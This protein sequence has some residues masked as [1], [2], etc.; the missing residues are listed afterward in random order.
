MTPPSLAM[1]GGAAGA[2][3]PFVVFL[4][5]VGWLALAGAPDERGFWP[6]LLAA[7]AV[8]LLLAKDRHQYSETL[9]AGMSQP[10]VLLMVMAWLLAGVLGTLMGAAGFV[11][12]LVW[13]TGQ[14]G[15]SGGAYVAAAFVACAAV[16]TST[17]TSFGTILICGPL[18]YPAGA[19]AGADPRVLAGA[20]LAGATF[21]DS[22][23]PISDTTIASSG[24]Q[25]ADI[26]GTVRARLK[27]VLPAGVVAAMA[28]LVLGAFAGDTSA[29]ASPVG[30]R[31]GG[32]PMALVPVLIVGLLLARRHLV[33][34]LMAGIA[35]AITIA[36]SFG[37]LSPAQLLRVES[38]SYA[39]KSLITDGLERGVGVTV[40][41]LL[42]VGL[43][44]GLEASGTLARLV[45]RSRT[46]GR[47]SARWTSE[48][49]IVAT[50]MGAVLV[51]THSVVAILAVGDYA[52]RAGEAVGITAYRRA[53][54]LDLAVCTWP[55][56]LPYFLPTILM[57]AATT[58]GEAAG[59]PRIAALDAGLFNF[60]SWGL[61]VMLVVAVAGGY[62]RKE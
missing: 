15:L 59:M 1:R 33:E 40:F 54:L 27:Y 21:G 8:G 28:Y 4:V 55:F 32:W 18:L 62:G 7:I 17:G 12:A 10:L 16:A 2:L 13:L 57:S 31:P 60:Y 48:M 46:S 56:L 58:S 41:T 43:V 19:G 35:A 39:A 14:L 49:R 44:A 11:Q 61:L 5:G 36:L 23:S 24:T 53:N 37:L 51:T 9:L 30:G 50:V 45:G 3:A 29:A 52:R 6:I 47:S 22:I 42:L 34:A 20:I 38:G 25:G 26:G